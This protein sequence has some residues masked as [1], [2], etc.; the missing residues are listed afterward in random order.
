MWRVPRF[1]QYGPFEQS[2]NVIS[3]VELESHRV[4]VIRQAVKI[5]IIAC[6]LTHIGGCA[7]QTP[8][9]APKILLLRDEGLGSIDSSTPFDTGDLRSHLPGFELQRRA[10]LAEHGSLPVILAYRDARPA[11]EVYP[12]DS[13][14]FIGELHVMSE[15]VRGPNG[16]AVGMTFAEAGGDRA[17][18]YPGRERFRGRSICIFPHSVI[19]YVYAASGWDGP[20]GVLPPEPYLS[21]AVLVRMIWR[22]NAAREHGGVLSAYRD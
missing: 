13:G 17:R 3:I 21:E 8:E 22:A 4:T 7:N 20:H 16:E 15:T 18:C 1:R 6:A 19:E 9:T 5:V 10:T 11:L 12:D 2:V 14:D